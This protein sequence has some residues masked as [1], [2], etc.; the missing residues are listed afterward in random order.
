MKVTL[1]WMSGID[2]LERT[3]DERMEQP[4]D[5]ADRV[6]ADHAELVGLRHGPG[7][8]AHQVAGLV[9]VVVEHRRSWYRAARTGHPSGR[10]FQ[11]I[12]RQPCALPF[13][14]PNASPTISLTPDS[15]YSRNTR[16]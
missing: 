13:E 11:D 12:R 7:N 2:G 1:Y 16:I 14:M 9:D 15:Q 10:R 8:H 6:S 5:L 3:I 4:V